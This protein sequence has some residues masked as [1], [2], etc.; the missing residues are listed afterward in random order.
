MS[1]EE[2]IDIAKNLGIPSPNEGDRMG[3]IYQISRRRVH[4]VRLTKSHY[5]ENTAQTRQSEQERNRPR[6]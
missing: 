4:I 2:L 6:I 3:L 1:Q 5:N